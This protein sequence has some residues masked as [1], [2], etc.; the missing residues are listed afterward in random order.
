MLV[1]YGLVK[2]FKPRV[3][4]LSGR[5]T[6]LKLSHP[7]NAFVYPTEAEAQIIAPYGDTYTGATK[8]T[9]TDTD[10][11]YLFDGW[12]NAT[13]TVVAANVADAITGTSQ[14]T[15]V[16]TMKEHV[17]FVTFMDGTA[18]VGY[19]ILDTSATNVASTLDFAAVPFTSARPTF[20]KANETANKNMTFSGTDA[21]KK[22][23]Y[24][25][26]GWYLNNS[27]SA[28]DT[29]AAV[30]ASANDTFYLKSSR[31]GGGGGGGGGSS[32]IAVAKKYSVNTA[33]SIEHGSVKIINKTAESGAS[34][35]FT[36]TPDKGYKVDNV[37]VTDENGNNLDVIMNNDGTYSLAM[38]ATAITVNATFVEDPS[39]TSVST[40]VEDWLI[41][42]AHDAY[43]SGY[44]DGTVK[45]QG[46]I[47]R[48]EVAMI[49]YR[50]LKNKNVTITAMFSDVPQ[51]SWYA[52][53]VST[54]AS[55]GIIKG[56]SDGT[57]E[58]MRSITRAE[59]ATIATRFAN[60]NDG[61]AT[62]SDVPEN[63][64]AYGNIASAAAY[65]WIKGY[66]DGTF[67]PQGN[68]TRAEVAAI[69]NRMTGRSADEAYIN[70]NPN[71]I[72]QF[73]DLQDVSKWYYLDMIEASNAHDFTKENSGEM[74]N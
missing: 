58:P 30:T 31:S 23:G 4:K 11:L 44:A 9:Y 34:V 2:T 63:H 57:Y 17:N 37:V 71:Q 41:C 29:K 1:M 68:I 73:T 55:V 74:W 70:A 62:F 66:T 60:A 10:D 27:T 56:V 35:T 53:A 42:D 61:I 38:P 40:G 5:T 21:Y 59:F 48:A 18:T 8:T 43:I 6:F 3:V 24:T 12:F 67:A 49:F 16:Y 54:L 36:V 69:V 32:N 47:T 22:S 72:K 15:D 52:E 14:S 50:L 7:A 33:D 19:G 39:E 28:V 20:G 51:D 65:G 46:N 26:N 64:W 45:P 25:L 13:D